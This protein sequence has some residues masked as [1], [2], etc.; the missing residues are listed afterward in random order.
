MSKSM[1][2]PDLAMLQDDMAT[3][4]RDV[5]NLLEH[6]K[7]GAA[8]GTQNAATRLNDGAQRLYENLTAGGKRSAT[9]IGKQVEEQ[10]LMA[11]LIALGVGFIGGRLLRH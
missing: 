11:V 2:D 6:L 1:T 7:L 4:K 5:L 3:L 8:N 9:A 10:P